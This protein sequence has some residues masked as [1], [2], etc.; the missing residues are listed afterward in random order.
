MPLQLKDV[1]LQQQ[2]E[3]FIDG[4]PVK[5]GYKRLNEPTDE[6]LAHLGM[7]RM[8]CCGSIQT[9]CGF[10]K[11]PNGLC[12]GCM[13]KLAVLQDRFTSYEGGFSYEPYSEVEYPVE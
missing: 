5:Y 1:T 7:K 8:S 2:D 10:V 3:T 13:V 6:N 11:G 12:E 9:R 4:M